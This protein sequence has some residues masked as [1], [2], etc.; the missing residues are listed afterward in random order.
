MNGIERYCAYEHGTLRELPFENSFYGALTRCAYRHATGVFVTNSDVLPSVA[1][2]GLE[3]ARVI[4]LPHAF[5]DRKLMRF[6]AE[7]PGLTPPAVPPVIFS[8]ARQH[9]KDRSGSWTK[10]NDI[11]F[12]AARIV[13]DEGFDFQLHLVAWGRDVEDSKALIAQLG[14]ADKVIWL[15]T[16]KKRELWQAYCKAHAVVDQFMLPALGG[17]AFEAMALGRRLITAIDEAQLTLFFGE[18][19]PCLGAQT[20]EECAGRL[21]QIV[22]DPE[23]TAGLGLAAQAWMDARH[24]ARR[25]VDIQAKA[26]LEFILTLNGLGEEA[27]VPA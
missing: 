27:V 6:R 14:I 24:S 25:I 16:M 9:W 3:P 1:R 2:M 12:R 21:R 4:H 10:G 22:S 19:P 20:V 13:A 5:D 18:A 17:V 23:D 7:N 15:P 8:P 26:Y 11:L